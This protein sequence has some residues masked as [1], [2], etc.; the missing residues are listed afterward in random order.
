MPLPDG[1]HGCGLPS[2]RSRDPARRTAGGETEEC[3]TDTEMPAP[4]YSRQFPHKQLIN[5]ELSVILRTHGVCDW[6]ACVRKRPA[7]VR[8]R[9]DAI[10]SSTLRVRR[11][12]V[13]AVR[14]ADAEG[15]WRLGRGVPATPVCG[16]HDL[17]A[18]SREGVSPHHTSSSRDACVLQTRERL[19]D[20]PL[21][22]P[23]HVARA[24][25][26]GEPQGVLDSRDPG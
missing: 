13:S 1:I 9:T 24:P 6:T 21:P 8:E 26:W 20:S 11:A 4:E 15:V 16:G 17:G 2:R 5:K 23:G 25:C 10:G 12:M 3:H 7:S 19:H 22:P 14:G 18:P